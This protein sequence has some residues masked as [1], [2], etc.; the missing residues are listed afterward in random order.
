VRTDFAKQSRAYSAVAMC[1]A[2]VVHLPIRSSVSLCMLACIVVK[3][4]T[5][6]KTVRGPGRGNIISWDCQFVA[7]LVARRLL[8][9]PIL[10]M[11]LGAGRNLDARGP[12]VGFQ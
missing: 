9:A 11:H 2:R 12:T 4:C 5:P 1:Y 10:G 7:D 3:G 6:T 8:V